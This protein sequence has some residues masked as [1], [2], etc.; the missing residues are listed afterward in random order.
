MKLLEAERMVV[1]FLP[2]LEYGT[3]TTS[4]LQADISL[5]SKRHRERRIERHRE[6]EMSATLLHSP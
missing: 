4:P 3:Y 1:V 5:E 6:G 2:P